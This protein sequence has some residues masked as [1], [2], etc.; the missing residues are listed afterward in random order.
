[1]FC[2][3]SSNVPSTGAYSIRAA[4][5]SSSSRRRRTH[6]SQALPLTNTASNYKYKWHSLPPFFT[7]FFNKSCKSK[8]ETST[9]T[10]WGLMI[11][12]SGLVEAWAYKTSPPPLPCICG[13]M[14]KIMCWNIHWNDSQSPGATRQKIAF[15]FIINNSELGLLKKEKEGG[16]KRNSSSMW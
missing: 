8:V 9:Q 2:R 14:I 7:M 16:G 3:G 1:M 5:S 13:T 4:G 15:L 12:V 10:A 6:K 11:G